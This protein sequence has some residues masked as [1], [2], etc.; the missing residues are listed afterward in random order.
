M[1]KGDAGKTSTHSSGSSDRFLKLEKQLLQCLK[2]V[3]FWSCDSKSQSI[4]DTRI[5]VLV[6]I[7][8]VCS[9]GSRKPP[10][11]PKHRRASSYAGDMFL[12]SVRKAQSEA[13]KYCGSPR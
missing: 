7:L 4:S 5:Q 9:F 2:N 12:R 13:V 8:N 1:S 3:I 11:I 6:K 10:L